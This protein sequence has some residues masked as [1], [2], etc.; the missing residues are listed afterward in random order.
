MS[1]IQLFEKLMG[2]SEE[3]E[4]QQRNPPVFVISEGDN[5]IYSFPECIFI[6]LGW[7]VART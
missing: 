2:K 1:K 7:T 6:Q 3:I 5:E 4:F